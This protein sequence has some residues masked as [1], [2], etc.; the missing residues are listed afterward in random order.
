MKRYIRPIITRVDC[1]VMDFYMVRATTN[2]NETIGD[3]GSTSGH[4]GV[5]VGGKRRGD[6]F[7][8]DE[9][10]PILQLLIDKETGN[11]SDLW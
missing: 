7:E 2:H 8:E 9:D 1:D 11:A 3:G 10:D 4:S 5:V 6:S